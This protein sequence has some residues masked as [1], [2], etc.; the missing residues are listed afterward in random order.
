MAPR[1]AARTPARPAAIARAAERTPPELELLRAIAG[2]FGSLGEDEALR[3]D[4]PSKRVAEL[5]PLLELA[6]GSSVHA[7]IA[8]VDAYP[9]SLLRA[10]PLESEALQRAQGYLDRG[11]QLLPPGLSKS[12]RWAAQGQSS[13]FISDNPC[14]CP[15]TWPR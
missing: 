8:A 13:A 1:P 5:G 2:A 6:K 3:S 10:M 7:A 14:H 4:A 11:A 9:L 15:L 12:C